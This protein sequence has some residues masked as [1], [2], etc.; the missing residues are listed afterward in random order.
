MKR[1]QFHLSTWLVLGF[2]AGAFVGVNAV[3]HQGRLIHLPAREGLDG[4][5][6]RMIVA[7]TARGWPLEYDEWYEDEYN[8]RVDFIWA[9][10]SLNVFLA[11]IV[12]TFVGLILERQAVFRAAFDAERGTTSGDSGR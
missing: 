3:P 6:P 7:M 2:V 4:P 5:R 1:F 9:A 12:L 8:R 10:L 11:L